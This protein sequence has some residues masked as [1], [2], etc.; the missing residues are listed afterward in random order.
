MIIS[1]RKLRPFVCGAAALAAI[2]AS[3]P[4]ASAFPVVGEPGEGA[5][6]ISK[7]HGVAVDIELERLYVA[8][9]GN[10]RVDAFDANTGEFEF[11]YG[12]GVK[13]GASALQTCTA[14]TTCR[15]GL[16]GSGAGQFKG[17]VSIAVDN[18]ASSSSHHDVYVFDAGGNDR[19]EKFDSAGSFLP[20]SFGEKGKGECQFAPETEG[21]HPI[22][23]GPGG[24]L[25]VADTVFLGEHETEGYIHRTEKF[26]PAGSCLGQFQLIKVLEGE[27]PV[28]TP[29][30]GGLAVDS[31]GIV[32]ASFA[33]FPSGPNSRGPAV[34]KYSAGGTLMETVGLC[35]APGPLAVDSADSL[36]IDC[37]NTVEEIDAAGVELR[38]F[39]YGVI[40]S[41]SVSGL[42]PYHS[43]SGEI[44]VAERD[45][46]G[47][48]GRVI[49][50]GFPDPGPIILLEAGLTN[51]N[52]VGNTKATL[53][54]EINPEGKATKYHAEYITEAAY[55]ENL[56]E[57]HEGFE[58][59]VRTPATEGEDPSLA[60]DFTVH[61]A[62]LIVGCLEPTQEKID[63]GE[64]LEP[65]TKYRFRIL[66]ENIDGEGNSPVEGEPFTTKKPLELVSSWSSEVTSESALL[67]GEVN[68]LGIP[69]SGHFLYIEEGP[70][71]Q[72]HGF[73]NALEAGPLDFGSS[74]EPTV[75]SVPVGG[76][77]PNTTY[78]YRLIASDPFATEPGPAQSFHTF[79]EVPSPRLPDGR[80]WEMVSPP[81]KNS[82]EVGVPSSAG[83]AAE[84]SVE[85]QQAAPDG[86]RLTY[87]S[88]TAFGE[89]P[90][91][92]PSTSQ[93]L[94]SLGPPFWATENI[95]PRFEEGF[96]TEPF[97]GFSGDLSRAAV[98][99][100]EPTLTEDATSGWPNLYV[101]DNET[102][103]YTA[104]TTGSHVPRISPKIQPSQYCLMFGGASTSFDH[105]IFAAFGALNEEESAAEGFNLYEWSAAAG[106]QLAS[107]LPTGTPASP[108][109][110]TGFGSLSGERFCKPTF[111]LMRHAISADGSRVF[112]TFGGT[113]SGAVDPLF[114]RIEGKETIQ[115]DKPQG[116]AGNGGEGEYWDASSDG[117]RVFFTDSQKLTPDAPASGGPDLYMYDFSEPEGERLSNLTVKGGGGANVQGVVGAS[118]NGAYVYFVARAALTTEP[119]PEGATAVAGD[120]NLYVWHE[121]AFSFIAALLGGDATDWSANP[122]VQS[123]R[124]TP[125]GL[126]LAFL[127]TARPT[128]FDNTMSDGS[129]CQLA[130]F[131]EDALVGSSA[132]SEAYLY[133]FEAGELI[134]ASCSPANQ[135][136]VGPARLPGWST[137][138]QQPRYISND[139][140]RVFFDTLDALDPRDTNGKRDVYE[141]EK[142]GVGDCTASSPS[143]APGSNG[144]ISLISSGESNDDSYLL[145]ASESGGGVFFSTRERLQPP[146]QD[147][148]FDVYDARIGG[149]V[150]PPEPPICEGSC[151][152]PGTTAEAPPPPNTEHFEGAPNK[153][154][155]ECP[156][157]THRVRRKGKEFC[158][159]PKHRHRRHHARRARGGGRK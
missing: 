148:R 117:S 86:S 158:V 147:E 4:A 133:D 155:R 97:V 68:P 46:G 89:D 146:D 35:L 87:G 51:A 1:R 48:Q 135:R 103:A 88:F 25:Y 140:S 102:G 154:L 3:A 9:F 100:R 156:K 2:A 110:P 49:Y 122:S 12:W 129:A 43:A 125:D 14:I 60:A 44:Y 114:A 57:A 62:S 73:D 107:R 136:P 126:H 76:L 109:E 65:E 124:V 7:P 17:L 151:P 106:I 53:N 127:S 41:S 141:F 94:S 27:Y 95:D 37:F 83:G 123:A 10:N 99:S 159:K 104:M 75:D 15:K 32:Y 69:A 63:N 130:Q 112:W 145:D 6:Q 128:G 28:G 47:G 84:F 119:N 16:A 22:A 142:E 5:G 74:E 39:G 31:S 70:D 138:Y 85:P 134:C 132:C 152:G 23:V 29:N 38:V 36:F 20:V 121:G 50:L 42:A 90:K 21:T 55:Q 59:A 101:R 56:A 137:P 26:D 105:V 45:S 66:A 78:H 72:E 30:V 108:K 111:G 24:N 54:A 52:P 91:S 150:P 82:G 77:S 153:P 93:Y 8:D 120:D 79:S 131:G 33:A 81:V 143:F 144:C 115:L 96:T 11:G 19:V 18:D 157:G 58:G 149:E 40:L 116:I 13:D 98:I 113:T 139:G 118:S 64:C 61:K 80:V 71:F 92:A 34:H 67:S